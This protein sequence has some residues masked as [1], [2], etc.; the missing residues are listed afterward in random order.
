MQYKLFVTFMP[1]ANDLRKWNITQT[2]LT[3][4]TQHGAL[5]GEQWGVQW[6]N[7]R[8]KQQCCKQAWLCYCFISLA[9]SPGEIGLKS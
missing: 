7:F 5:V 1:A 9:P 2:E 4:D 6:E 8:E 3:K